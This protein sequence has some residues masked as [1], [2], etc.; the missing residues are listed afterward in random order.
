MKGNWKKEKS[1]Y[2]ILLDCYTFWST[3]HPNG[4]AKQFLTKW[5]HHYEY[6]NLYFSNTLYLLDICSPNFTMSLNLWAIIFPLC[7]TNYG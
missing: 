2:F 1:L 5:R 6:G 3:K 7:L 4:S